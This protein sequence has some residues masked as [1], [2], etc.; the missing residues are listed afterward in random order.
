MSRAYGN[1]SQR[2]YRVLL[3]A[4]PT[5]FRNAFRDEMIQT[6]SDCYR[7]KRGEGVGEI[8]RLWVHT[9][10]DLLVSAVK[11]HNESEGSFMNNLRKMSWQS[12][13]V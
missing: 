9:L 6:F 5:E 13:D 2:V 10:A 12:L 3:L 8:L 1:F 11:E 4:Y 7:A